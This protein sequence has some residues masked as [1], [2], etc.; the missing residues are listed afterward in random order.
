MGV[1]STVRS[2]LRILAKLLFWSILTGVAVEWLFY[3]VYNDGEI[4]LLNSI[5]VATLYVAIMGGCQHGMGRLMSRYVSLSSKSGVVIHVTMLSLTTLLSFV[6]ATGVVRLLIGPSFQIS[7]K[8]L[9]VIALV[10]FTASL[11][12]NSFGYAKRIRRAEKEA[13]AAEL[14]ALRAQINPHLLF[15]ALN[16]IAALI[17]TRPAEAEAV[18]ENLADLFRYSLRASKQPV[19]TLADELASV[20]LYLSIERTRF[21]D[22]L[23]VEMAVP[24]SLRGVAM[25]SLLLQPLVENAVKHGVSQ[26]LGACTVTIRAA[27][28]AGHV[29][30]RV[31]DTGPG[32]ADLSDPEAILARGTGLANIRDRLRLHFGPSARFTLHP[33]G[34]AL[35]FP[36]TA[37]TDPPSDV[38]PSRLAQEE[39]VR[40]G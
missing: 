8:V 19:V 1:P 31:A 29:D 39:A 18:T 5:A 6:L 17:R 13:V 34:V 14:R 20:D 28:E 32:F 10:A 27:A 15:H 38:Q 37:P 24:A 33:D 11:A 12:G 26:T 2:V 22:R 25:P 23:Q 35:R 4:R 40:M 7:L 36:L 30:L 9:A 3:L 16:T 21:R